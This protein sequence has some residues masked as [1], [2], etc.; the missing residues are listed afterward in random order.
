MT[1]LST[2]GQV[3]LVVQSRNATFINLPFVSASLVNFFIWTIY[4]LINKDV[5]FV[6]SQFTGFCAMTVNMLFYMWALS[7]PETMQA[8]G[9]FPA[10]MRCLLK[11]VK[12]LTAKEAP[13]F[14]MTKTKKDGF[15]EK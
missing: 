4:A 14:E 13:Q 6:A 2:L 3:P 8:G 1:S 7:T 15:Q 5:I 10:T 9:M 12:R 11:I